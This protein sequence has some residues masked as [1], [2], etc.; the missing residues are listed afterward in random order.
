MSE[1]LKTRAILLP[2]NFPLRFSSQWKKPSALSRSSFPFIY[3]THAH[4]YTRNLRA[5][6]AFDIYVPSATA[7]NKK[8]VVPLRSIRVAKEERRQF[9]RVYTSW[10]YI[11]RPFGLFAHRI[12]IRASWPTNRTPIGIYKSQRPAPRR[13]KYIYYTREWVADMYTCARCL[14]STKGLWTS[15]SVGERE[16]EA[17]FWGDLIVR[18]ER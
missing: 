18:A 13:R 8:K 12:Y 16:R 1:S 17:T 14:C 7:Q 2:A 11:Y 4:I 10:V 15:C 5:R 6:A 3:N 9:R